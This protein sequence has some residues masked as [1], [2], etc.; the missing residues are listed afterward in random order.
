M[1]SAS[2]SGPRSGTSNEVGFNSAD[3]GTRGSGWKRVG[4]AQKKW[5]QSLG[6]LPDHHMKKF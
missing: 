6:N 2:N 4:V 5:E 3:G 1:I